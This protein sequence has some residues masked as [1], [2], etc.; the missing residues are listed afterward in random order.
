VTKD[1]TPFI[2]GTGEN[3]AF[4][5]DD[6]GVYVVTLTATDK[7]NASNEATHTVMVDNAPPVVSITGDETGLEGSPITLLGTA[8]DP[9]I[10]DILEVGWSVTKDGESFADGTEP[11]IDFTPDD[12]GTY[13]VTLTASDE[14]GGSAST[15]HTVMVGNVAPTVD[16][17]NGPTEASLGTEITVDATFTDPGLL[18]T[19]TA[20]WDW[21]DGTTTDPATLTQ[22]AGSGS[23]T[24]SH[25]YLASGE[26]TI[27]LIITD[28]DGD[29]GS[30]SHTV[31]IQSPVQA[32]NSLIEMVEAIEDLPEGT[33]NELISK[34]NNTLKDL[35]KGNDNAATGKL[36]AFINSV[37]AQR[38][39]KISE[40]DA[41]VLIQMA[42]GIID[43]INNGLS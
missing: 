42:Q 30:A 38:G 25:T 32:I 28:K 5:P 6:E 40:A 37:E 39:K 8:T 14:D 18:D 41:D 4:T 2:S 22:G 43:A 24:D 10:N 17:I 7:D 34:L 33:Q 16:P 13:E 29:V 19:H 20:I 3:I 21:G 31:M 36:G 35:D 12:N 27:Q 1:D 9:G 15:T 11:N 23:V 26:Y